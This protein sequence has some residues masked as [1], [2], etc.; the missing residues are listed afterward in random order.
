MSAPKNGTEQKWIAQSETIHKQLKLTVSYKPVLPQKC[1]PH[2][3][4]NS[5][6]R[7]L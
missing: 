4:R 6:A 7:F 2:Q 1:A 3:C 5:F